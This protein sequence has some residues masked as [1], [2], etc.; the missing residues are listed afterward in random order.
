MTRYTQG[1]SENTA[2]K[3]RSKNSERLSEGHESA[4]QWQYLLGKPDELILVLFKPAE[5]VLVVFKL[6]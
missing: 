5:L 1:T 6:P 3:T 4:T 2:E